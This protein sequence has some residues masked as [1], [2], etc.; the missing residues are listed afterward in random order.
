M[1]D[2]T[3]ARSVPPASAPTIYDIAARAGVGI[4]TVSRV[5]NGS[6]R[7]SDK[8]RKAVQ[9]AM[10]ELGFRPNNAA[11][12]LAAGAP[13]RPRVVALMPFFTTSFYF[14]VCKALSRTLADAGTDLVLVDVTHQEE[15]DRHLDRLLAERSCEGVVLCS[16]DLSE[17]RRDQFE[18]LHI[19]IIALDYA[20]EA[21]PHV[22]VDNIEGG[23]LLSRTLS[24][25][26]CKHQALIIG[27][28][29]SHAFRDRELGFRDVC[30]DGSRV[31]EVL[32]DTLDSGEEITRQIL[33]TFPEVDGIACAGDL[34]A[35]GALTAVRRAGRRVP[36]DVQIIGFD[37]QPMM[38]VMGLTTIRQPMEKFGLWG[39]SAILRMIA[40][41]GGEPPE[42]AI[43]PLE[44]VERGTTQRIA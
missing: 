30:P 28:R 13:N 37:D 9:K 41:P 17:G 18:I 26:G 22:R 31:Y 38:D 21:I 36:E 35:V 43:L 12:R 8:T 25:H 27:T 1:Q 19:P 23:R 7:V 15:A 14:N 29:S 20:A 33:E 42:T 32:R 40:S 6:R 5:I 2:S 34:L 10:S 24:R 16:M 39:G 4:A 11:R 44:V 3:S